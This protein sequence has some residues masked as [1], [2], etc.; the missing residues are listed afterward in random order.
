[1]LLRYITQK[2]LELLLQCYTAPSRTEHPREMISPHVAG[3]LHQPT[4][5]LS[6]GKG[7]KVDLLWLQDQFRFKSKTVCEGLCQFSAKCTGW[8]A[9]VVS[10][11]L[12]PTPAPASTPAADCWQLLRYSEVDF[13]FAHDEPGCLFQADK[14]QAS[15]TH[16]VPT[17]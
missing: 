4:A 11:G 17:K 16:Q 14:I 2:D 1:M 10:W 9:G 12:T 13:V 5:R 15:A 8:A 3:A 7:Q 6:K